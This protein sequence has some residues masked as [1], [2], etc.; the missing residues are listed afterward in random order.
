MMT[1]VG[2]CNTPWHDY[3][4]LFLGILTKWLNDPRTQYQSRKSRGACW[5]I[6]TQIDYK[7]LRGQAI[8]P[9]ILNQNGQNDVE[10]HDQWPL[11]SIPA[12]SI[13]GCMFGANLVIPAQI[14]DELLR[15]TDIWTDTQ[16]DRH[17][18]QQYSCS[19][20]GQGV[21]SKGNTAEAA[22]VGKLHPTLFNL[23][24]PTRVQPTTPATM[25]PINPARRWIVFPAK[26]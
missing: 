2:T 19:L 15:R 12:K 3:W 1:H 20:K 5:V 26:E 14:F 16:T 24:L 11:F 4:K 6:L 22:A 8:F 25:Q 21:I 13:P 9:R 18:Q 17:R 7:L 23:N 10:C